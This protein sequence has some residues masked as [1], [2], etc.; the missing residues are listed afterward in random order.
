V[1]LGF[2]IWEGQI[3]KKKKLEGP[4]L[5]KKKKIRGFFLFLGETPGL[6]RARPPKARGSSALTI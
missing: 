5:K 2:R 1:E 4:K 6:G 3:E